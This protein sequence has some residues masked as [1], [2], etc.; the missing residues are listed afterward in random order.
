MDQDVS[1]IRFAHWKKLIEEANSSGMKKCEWCALHGVTE[2]Q[3]FYWQRKVRAAAISEM[4][5]RTKLLPGA[6][7]NTD[8]AFVE[9]KPPVQ[10][11][12]IIEDTSFL[13]DTSSRPAACPEIAIVSGAFRVLLGES[14]SEKALKKVLRAMRDA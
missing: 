5:D 8:G 14:F 2:K 7:Q 4:R 3:F 9:L 1:A 10:E 12:S 13:A 6:A 11:P